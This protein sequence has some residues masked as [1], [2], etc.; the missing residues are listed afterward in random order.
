M[1]RSL[2][3]F[4]LASHLLGE[5]REVRFLFVV[6]L[7]FTFLLVFAFSLLLAPGGPV[8][9]TKHVV[10]GESENLECADEE[11]KLGLDVAHQVNVV[12][13][14]FEEVIRVF[15][16]VNFHQIVEQVSTDV[17]QI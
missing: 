12:R 5:I 11:L 3:L 1:G 4:S 6:F 15:Q 14:V 9:F 7:A 13:L 8:A 2:D 10:L 16:T 17:V